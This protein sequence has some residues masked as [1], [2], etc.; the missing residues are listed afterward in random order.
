MKKVGIW[1]DKEKAHVVTLENET[2]KL[3]T[4]MSEVE[5]FRPKGGSGTR[6][7]GGPQDV[8]QDS[9]YLE[10]E[11]HQLKAYFKNL[12]AIIK[13]AD[14]IAIFGPADTY[15]KFHRELQDQYKTIYSKVKGIENADSMTTNQTKALVRGF[16][17][18]MN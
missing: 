11:K 9:K 14:A 8:V 13:H 7:K 6:L 10:R 18:S 5:V 1:I 3:K 12:A 15:K 17:K 4:I 16:F 2:E